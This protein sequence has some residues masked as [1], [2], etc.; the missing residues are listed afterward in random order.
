MGL[1]GRYDFKG[2]QKLA[3]AGVNV[4]LGATQWGA[5]L[6]ASPFRGSIDAAE[7]MIINWLANRGLI[8]LDV[9]YFMV[10]GAIDQKRL[11]QALTKGL[12]RVQQGR[13]KITPA[14][15]KAIDDEVREAFD[16]D[17]D[18]GISNSV[19]HVSSPSVRDGRNPTV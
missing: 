3:S 1:T 19:Q 2:I 8:V 9:G 4:A 7:K 14:E 5:W 18:L 15:G 16:A 17:A 10:N 13:D 12:Q 11:D 6:L